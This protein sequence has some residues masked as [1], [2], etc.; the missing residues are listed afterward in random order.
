MI[1]EV[2]FNCVIFKHIHICSQIINYIT[3]K[4]KKKYNS[5]VIC[6]KN[7]YIIKKY[8]IISLKVKILYV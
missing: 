7:T 8:F 2:P 1:Y 3:C 4:G 5:I 6:K